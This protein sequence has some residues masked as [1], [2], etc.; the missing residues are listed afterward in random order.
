MVYNAAQFYAAAAQHHLNPATSAASLGA[1][2]S[3]PHAAAVAAQA[4]VA[5]AGLGYS[6]M[7]NGIVPMSMFP[8][9]YGSATSNGKLFFNSI[10][11]SYFHSMNLQII[12][13]ST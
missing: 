7:S 13:I 11:S 4:A 9:H 2:A 8:G 12:L 3:N 1:V 6:S 5:A 10:R